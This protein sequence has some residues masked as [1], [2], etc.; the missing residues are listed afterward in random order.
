MILFIIGGILFGFGIYICIKGNQWLKTANEIQLQRTEEQAKIDAEI[1]EKEKEIL[2]LNDSKAKLEFDITNKKQQND[3]FYEN[4]KNRIQESLRVYEDLIKSKKNT[5]EQEY[6]TVKHNLLQSQNDLQLSL[7]IEHQ[8][9]EKEVDKLRQTLR[10]GT[11]AQLREREKEEKLDFY[12][13]QVSQTELDDIKQLAAVKLML[14]EPVILSKLI[15]TQ[16]FQKQTTELCNRILG[17]E[18]VCGIYKITNILT[19]QC[20]VGQSVDVATRWKDHTKCGLGIE[21]S[22]TNKLYN[23]M[24]K[25]GVWNFTYELLEACERKELDEKEKQWIELYSSAELGFNTTKGN[26]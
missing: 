24:Q 20:Y 17:K 21:A 6:E 16:Y 8:Q 5:L 18:K 2:K 3:I 23:S 10:A 15:W 12:K 4:E 11:E 19:Q 7:Q 22:A 25:D 9:L 1:Q 26:G 13:L 14:H